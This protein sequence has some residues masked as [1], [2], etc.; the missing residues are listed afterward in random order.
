MQDLPLDVEALCHCLDDEG[1]GGGHQ[2]GDGGLE[3]QQ[4]LHAVTPLCSHPSLLLLV[5]QEAQ[6]LGAAALQL[7][8]A[9]LHHSHGQ[10]GHGRSH[11]RDAA[12]HLTAANHTD[13]GHAMSMRRA[14]R[15]AVPLQAQRAEGVG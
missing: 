12:A 5:V 4:L 14:E 3:A 8:T 1:S 6:E 13:T 7:S 2:G 11:E 10:T 15:T 9:R